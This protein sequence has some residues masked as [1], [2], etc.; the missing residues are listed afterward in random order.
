MAK[1]LTLIV[2]ASDARQAS[3]WRSSLRSRD[4]EPLGD[5]RSYYEPCRVPLSGSGMQGWRR[6]W[7]SKTVTNPKRCNNFLEQF[8]SHDLVQRCSDHRRK[9]LAGLPDVAEILRAFR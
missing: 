9:L 3:F 1:V 5:R 2:R 8:L 4:F 7:P 6:C